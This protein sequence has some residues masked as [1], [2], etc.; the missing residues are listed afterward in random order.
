ML[1]QWEQHCK[2]TIGE[3][4]LTSPTV[5]F[6]DLDRE[7]SPQSFAPLLEPLPTRDSSYRVHRLWGSSGEQ[8]HETA[9][10][11]SNAAF[12]QGM[13]S[14]R[15]LGQYLGVFTTPG[16]HNYILFQLPIPV[17]LDTRYDKSSRT[18]TAALFYRRPWEPSEF[19]VRMGSRWSLSLPLRAVSD[20]TDV[21]NGWLSATVSHQI[22]TV[23]GGIQ[24]WAGWGSEPTQ[25]RW[26]GARK[27]GEPITPEL[28]RRDFLSPFYDLAR[29]A[30]SNHIGDAQDVAFRGGQRKGPGEAVFETAIANACGALGYPVLFGGTT[31]STQGVDLVAFQT[32]G[33]IAYAISVTVGTDL[34]GKIR[35]LRLVQSRLLQALEPVWTV[36]LVVITGQPGS[37]VIGRDKQTAIEEKVLVLTVD[38]LQGLREQPPD[39]D[40]FATALQRAVPHPATRIVL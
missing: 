37:V 1:D 15:W 32:Q 35:Q 19:W 36:K 24:V 7:A 40:S 33:N 31:L 10:E 25:F 12:E 17:A 13:T 39:L 34:D 9:N 29:Q 28:R 16:V 6:L 5:N 11:V 3:W 8:D 4:E 27:L 2:F 18:V 30:L 20:E 38:D 21:G 22:D 14:E 26:A 23:D